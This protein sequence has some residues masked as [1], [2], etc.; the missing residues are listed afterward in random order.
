VHALV[1]LT[2]G[3]ANELVLRW[4]STRH[5]LTVSARLEPWEHGVVELSDAAG[6]TLQ[7]LQVNGAREIDLVLPAGTHHLRLLD[8]RGRE[9]EAR[10]LVLPKSDTHPIRLARRA[11]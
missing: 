10:E 4:P 5:P 7:R 3:P 2:E 9:V 6:A 1:D 11:R 8:P